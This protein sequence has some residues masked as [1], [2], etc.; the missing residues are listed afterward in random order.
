MIFIIFF[1]V[2]LSVLIFRN[3]YTRTHPCHTNYRV[4]PHSQNKPCL[5]RKIINTT[6]RKDMTRTFSKS[7]VHIQKQF[8]DS[9]TPVCKVG[10]Y[11]SEQCKA[12]T[13]NTITTY[14]HSKTGG[15]HPSLQRR[16]HTIGHF[17]HGEGGSKT[18]PLS[19]QS[20][21]QRISQRIH[22]P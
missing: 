21:C 20:Q 14:H 15:N 7:S 13:D 5:C 11:V 6:A 9:L 8:Q 19:K 3:T 12:L 10:P 4:A 18:K 1:V 22:S 2:V 16:F 17:P